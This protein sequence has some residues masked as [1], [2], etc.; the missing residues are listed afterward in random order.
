[1]VLLADNDQCR[2]PDLLQAIQNVHA[3]N[4]LAAANEAGDRRIA[5]V[6]TDALHHVLARLPK[7]IGEPAGERGFDQGIHAL[8]LRDA[9]A[10]APHLRGVGGAAS[11]RVRPGPRT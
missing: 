11:R 6:P 5:D 9:Y 1:M 2:A 4:R 10:L 8:R 7:R 3:R